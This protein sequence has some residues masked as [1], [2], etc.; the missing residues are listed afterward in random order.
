MYQISTSERQIDLDRPHTINVP[1]V[2]L[3]VESR[4]EQEK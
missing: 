1:V 4:Y 3:E 2:D